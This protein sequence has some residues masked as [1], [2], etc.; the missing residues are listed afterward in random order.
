MRDKARELCREEERHDVQRRHAKKYKKE[1]EIH[2]A[3][4]FSEAYMRRQ[5][6]YR[7][8]L[9]TQNILDSMRKADLRAEGRSTIPTRDK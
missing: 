7:E 3:Q 8:W 2:K 9:A 1:K 4:R 5:E 6:H